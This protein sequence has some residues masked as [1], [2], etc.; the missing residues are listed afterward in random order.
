MRLLL[1]ADAFP[2]MRTSAAVQMHDLSV[3]LIN[4]G[5]KIV[6]IVPVSIN[7]KPFSIETQDGY[8]VVSVL[9]PKTK[10]VKFMRRTFAEFM[11]PYIILHRL[12]GSA[13]LDENYEGII[14]YSPTIFFS[15]LISRL[16]KRFRCPA[17]LVLRD[18]FPDWALD[19]GL[20]KKAPPYYLLK[21]FA[22]QQYKVANR[23]GVQ[24]PS[25]LGYFDRELLK[26]YKNKVELLWNWISSAQSLNQCSI[27]LNKTHLAGRKI[28][29]YTG[30]IGKAQDL[31]FLMSMVEIFGDRNDI[32]FVFVGRGS[33]VH[34][35][36]NKLHEK[37]L[38][39]FIFFDEIEHIEMP[40][41][42]SQCTI[43]LVSLSPLH[44]SSNIPGKFLSYMKSGLPVLARLNADN[45]LV[46]LINIHNVG[47]CYIGQDL[48]ELNELA[49]NLLVSLTNDHLV[50]TRCKGLA[51]S[52]FS[53][54][55]AARQIIRFLAF[56]N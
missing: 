39:N 10:D 12:K 25:D 45:D 55:N 16:K 31:E 19:L 51:H 35:L 1:I 17:Y 3:E 43:G 34:H 33:E 11:V 22:L 8:K 20:I 23:I 32:G 56:K 24:A 27:D 21:L 42:Y 6:V 54:E 49:N 9:A 28:F 40:A 15:P 50:S 7:T 4:Q 44:R 38:D 52:L 36:K 30:N 46:G 13:I 53:T 2:P 47:A 29:I 14:W 5:H 26:K 48:V 18:L 41:L 37:A